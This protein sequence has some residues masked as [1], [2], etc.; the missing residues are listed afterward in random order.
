[1]FSMSIELTGFLYLLASC[2]YLLGLFFTRFSY[3]RLYIKI[4]KKDYQHDAVEND[5]VSKN[6]RE[7]ALSVVPDYDRDRDQNELRL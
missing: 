2:K 6:R 5:R 7:I 1:M 4:W 3:V